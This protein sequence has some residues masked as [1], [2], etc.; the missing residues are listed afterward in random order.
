[1]TKNP[2][3]ATV[4]CQAGNVDRVGEEAVDAIGV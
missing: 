3:R 2:L 1:M 4:N